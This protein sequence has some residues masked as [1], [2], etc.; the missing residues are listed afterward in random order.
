MTQAIH[1]DYLNS[2]VYSRDSQ[3]IE[4][5]EKRAKQTTGLYGRPYLSTDLVVQAVTGAF[6]HD[7]LKKFEAVLEPAS[8]L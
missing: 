8:L 2:L 6:H 5:V 3:L 4:L 7:I 1:M